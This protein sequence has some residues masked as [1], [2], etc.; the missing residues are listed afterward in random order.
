MAVQYRNTIIFGDQVVHLLLVIYL[1][2]EVV[3]LLQKQFI[4]LKCKDVVDTF[5]L[6]IVIV[7]VRLIL[8]QHKVLNNCKVG[9]STTDMERKRV[10]TCLARKVMLLLLT[11]AKFAAAAIPFR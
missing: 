9:Y 8:Y 1:L 4:H 7:T 11:Q 3:L 6:F 5:R 10:V 2:K